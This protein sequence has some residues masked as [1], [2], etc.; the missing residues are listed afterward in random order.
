[1][2]W[3]DLTDPEWPESLDLARLLPRRTVE[4][5]VLTLLTLPVLYCNHTV[6]LIEGEESRKLPTFH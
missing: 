3:P 6:H 1:M 4:T 5:V 2:S